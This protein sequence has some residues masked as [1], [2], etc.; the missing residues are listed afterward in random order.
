MGFFRECKH[1]CLKVHQADLDE[2]DD[3]DTFKQK[4]DLAADLGLGG[5][6]IWAVDQDDSEL[7][8][9]QAVISPKKLGDFKNKAKDKSYW[10]VRLFIAWC[11]QP[12]DPC[13]F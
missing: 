5:Y 3:A 2:K 12:Q 11:Y 13:T 1:C 6:L 7:S 8:A 10:E 9:L 4:K